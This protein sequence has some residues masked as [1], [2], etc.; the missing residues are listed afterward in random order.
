MVINSRSKADY[1]LFVHK[2]TTSSTVILVY[3]DDVI[4]PDNDLSEINRIKQFL[5]DSLKIKDLGNLKFFLELG[6]A[7]SRSGIFLYQRKYA[8]DILTDTGY[9]TA[10]PI[11]TPVDTN[12]ELSSSIRRAFT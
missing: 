6:I 10:K 7:R 11:S 5:D 12:L 1:S 8:M 3:V 4:L 9:L 2:R